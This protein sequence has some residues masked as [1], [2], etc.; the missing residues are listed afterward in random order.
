M[1]WPELPAIPD[2]EET[3][4]M[5]PLG[6]SRPRSSRV[7]LIRSSLERLISINFDQ[8]SSGIFAIVRSRVTPALWTR[9]SMPLADAVGDPRR[10]VLGGDV[11]VDRL[12]AELVGE[13]AE[14]LGG[15]RDVEADDVGAVAGEDLG[16]RRADPA[17]G[18]GDQR[19]LPS[20]GRSQS[21]SGGSA[22]AGPT[23]TTCPET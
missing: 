7:S 6:R 15:G 18:A 1:V 3:Q 9:T 11:E 14:I 10:R 21:S 23:L 4:T 19:R 13:P 2:I 20:S 12:P 16:D 17:R 22:T 5:R 8:R